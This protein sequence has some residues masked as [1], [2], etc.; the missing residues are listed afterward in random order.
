MPQSSTVRNGRNSQVLVDDES[1][2][3]VDVS[4]T[5]N[6]WGLELDNLTGQAFTFAGEYPRTIDGKKNATLSV[7]FVY[8]PT[9]NEGADLLRDWF[10]N[11]GAR[12]VSISYPDAAVGSDQITGEFRLDDLS[13]DAEAEDGTP[14][15][16]EATL[17]PDGTL[18]N[19]TISS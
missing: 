13:F 16:Y 9:A 18:T 3:P 7:R 14:M 12:T 4:G 15:M 5:G 8:S 11:Q 19:T 17:L 10:N 2:S 6:Q 1:G